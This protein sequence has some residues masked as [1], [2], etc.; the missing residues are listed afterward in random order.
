VGCNSLA[1][2][3]VATPAGAAEVVKHSW[4]ALAFWDDV[5][6]RHRLPGVRFSGVAIRA[7]P[8]VGGEKLLS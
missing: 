3:F 7:A 8:I 6:K 5:I 1:F 4:A 2:E